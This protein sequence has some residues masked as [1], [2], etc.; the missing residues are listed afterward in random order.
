M[1]FNHLFILL[2]KRRYKSNHAGRSSQDL[3]NSSQINPTV[4]R[5]A[6]Q[7]SHPIKTKVQNIEIMF[8][9]FISII[10]M[11]RKQPLGI[12][13]LHSYH[14]FRHS[15]IVMEI[16]LPHMPPACYLG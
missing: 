14:T 8:M 11:D 7:R 5:G 10:Y 6:P 16:G 15:R 4:G 1:F 13:M 3:D 2:P 12:G 9:H